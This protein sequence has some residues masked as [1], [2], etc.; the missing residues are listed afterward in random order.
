MRKPFTRTEMKILIYNKTKRGMDYNKAKKEVEM[1][2]EQC[3]E[4]S[5]KVKKDE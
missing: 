1:E 5:E 4:N 3:M 2:I